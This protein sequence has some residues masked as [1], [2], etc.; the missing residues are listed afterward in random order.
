M[1]YEILSVHRSLRLSASVPK[2]GNGPSPF[3]LGWKDDLLISIVRAY[4]THR[5][6]H[7]RV[8]LEDVRNVQGDR[9]MFPGKAAC[10]GH[11]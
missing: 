7:G 9:L 8:E 2:P 10:L 1:S 3:S 6:G 4:H 5:M 11:T